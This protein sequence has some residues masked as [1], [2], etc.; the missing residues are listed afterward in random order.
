[1]VL[2]IKSVLAPQDVREKLMSGDGDFQRRMV[3]YL[4][5]AHQGEFIGENHDVVKDRVQESSSLPG[6]EDPTQTMPEMAPPACD[7]SD[8]T[9]CV[10]CDALK[11]WWVRFKDVV[12]DILLKSNMHKCKKTCNVNGR[13]DC[14]A[15]F[16]RD[17]FP[18]T[19]LDEATGALTMKKGEERMNTFNYVLTYLLRCNSD[20]TS[21]LSGAAMKAV[22]AYVTEYVTKTG[23]KTYHVFDIIR[24]VF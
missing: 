23:L 9:G 18:H 19:L 20:V 7:I 8:C 15:R 24:S 6:Y 16:P 11:G 1:M 13:L 2:W 3:E 17:T 21:L 5:G 14:K 10:T 4:E 22:V 12:N